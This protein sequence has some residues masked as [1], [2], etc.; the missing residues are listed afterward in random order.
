VAAPLEARWVV[1]RIREALPPLFDHVEPMPYVALQQLF[2]EA[3]AWGFHDYD[4]GIYLGDFTDGAIEMLTDYASRKSSAL[5]FV[6][7]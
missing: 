2:D 5:S 3:S 7:T 6:F 1:A 4:K